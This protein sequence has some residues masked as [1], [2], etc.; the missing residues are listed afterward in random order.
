M[1]P[2]TA[3]DLTQSVREREKK[4]EAS[5]R[6]ITTRLRRVEQA[7]DDTVRK[8]DERNRKLENDLESFK[9]RLKVS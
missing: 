4:L 1:T 9:T 8:L 7:T 6:E 3:M 5:W 2:I